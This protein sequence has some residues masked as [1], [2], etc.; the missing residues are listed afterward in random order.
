MIERDQL[1]PGTRFKTVKSALG[2]DETLDTIFVVVTGDSDLLVGRW[3]PAVREKSFKTIDDPSTHLFLEKEVAEIVPFVVD[4]EMAKFLDGVVGVVE[5]D[6]YAK[7]MLWM[8]NHY[9]AVELDH[10]KLDWKSDQMGMMEK[11]GEIAGMPVCI[12]LFKAEIDGQ[13]ILFVD[14]C[15]MVVDH[16]LIDAWYKQTL[17][18]SAFRENG[19][20]NKTDAMNFHNVLR[21]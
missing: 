14:P 20:V 16:R 3:I 18:K 11:V 12:S 7:H 1:I 4:E 17:P 21:G 5:A 2:A 13:A 10:R 9:K 6:N 19:Y 8:E 15:S